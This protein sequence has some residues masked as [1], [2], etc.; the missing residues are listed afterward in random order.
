MLSLYCVSH[1]EIDL[2]GSGVELIGVSGAAGE[3]FNHSD[4]SGVSLSHFNARFSELTGH[5][6]V[7]K[8]LQPERVESAVGFCHYRRFLLP[9]SVSK[10]FANNCDRP[11]DNRDK[12]GE[13]NYASGYLIEQDELSSMFATCN[14]VDELDD[15][16][17]QVDI[18]LPRSNRLQPGGFKAQYQR[19]HPAEPFDLMLHIMERNDPEMAQAASEFFTDFEYAYW[20]NL[21]ITR[22][23]LFSEYCDLA[24]NILLQVNAELKDYDGVYQNRVCAFL[25]ERLFNFW[26]Y[27]KNLTITELDWCV[28]SEIR[29]PLESHQVAI[30]I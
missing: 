23:E 26:I 20:N 10:W 13:G 18:V 12:G 29:Q 17:K 9:P 6:Y 25:S 24:F 14:Y 19:C 28:T 1:K 2:Q 21:F 11:F 7:W 22:F 15:V 27:Y 16:G 3:L 4:T 5:Y 8:N 30:K